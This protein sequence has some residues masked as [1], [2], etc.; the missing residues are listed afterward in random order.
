MAREETAGWY[1]DKQSGTVKSEDNKHT[2]D[3]VSE[4]N[5]DDSDDETAATNGKT[6]S[7]AMDLDLL[8]GGIER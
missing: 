4:W 1:Y 3:V 7:F 5:D 6:V 2:N 8:K